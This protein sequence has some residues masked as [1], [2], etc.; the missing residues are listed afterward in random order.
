VLHQAVALVNPDHRVAVTHINRYQH[1]RVRPLRSSIVQ[2]IGG[3]R[4]AARDL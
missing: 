4:I 1:L 2:G 3:A